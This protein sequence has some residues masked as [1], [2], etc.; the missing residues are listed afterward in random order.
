M[1]DRK[2]G[3]L[4]SISVLVV[5]SVIAIVYMMYTCDKEIPVQTI[6]GFETDDPVHVEYFS[7]QGCPHC[8]A[9]DPIWDSVKSEVEAS[10]TAT[11]VV[12]HKYE[13]TTEAGKE[14]AAEASVNAFPHIRKITSDGEVTVFNGKRD[15]SSLKEFCDAL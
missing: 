8:K 11:S 3:L 1:I 7:M 5:V 9:F 10:D 13:V 6:D 4:I 12:L 14:K 2:T 15:E